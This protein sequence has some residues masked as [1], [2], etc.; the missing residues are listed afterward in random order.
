MTNQST[1]LKLEHLEDES[2]ESYISESRMR[3]DRQVVFNVVRELVNAQFN[4]GDHELCKR[5]WQ[6][7]ADRN[8]DLER[9]IYLMYNCNFH[10]DEEL[11]LETDL[12]YYN[13]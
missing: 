13:T 8:I 11:M 2:F 12:A 10:D 1:S 6:D 3:N 9:V 4:L 5:L 7:I